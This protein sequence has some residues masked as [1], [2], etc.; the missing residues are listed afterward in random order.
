MRIII[1]TTIMAMSTA[2]TATSLDGFHATAAAQR[3]DELARAFF[4]AVNADDQAR[5]DELLDRGFQSYDLRGTRSRTGLHAYYAGLRRSFADL[6]FDVHENVGVLVQGD[7]LALRTIV[8]GTHTGEYAGVAA[9]GGAIQTSASH[10][11]RVGASAVSIVL[12]WGAEH[13]DASATH[14]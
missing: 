3:K 8:T 13:H 7:M 14:S 10:I 2:T 4:D 12:G 9:T 1:T 11:F 6:R 5:I